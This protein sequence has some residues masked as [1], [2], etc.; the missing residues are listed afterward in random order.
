[1]FGRRQVHNAIIKATYSESPH[2]AIPGPSG[3]GKALA[4]DTRVPTP[5]GWTTMGELSVGDEVFTADGSP[6]RVIAATEIMHGHPCYEI[7][8]S[9]GSVIVADGGHMWLVEDAAARAAFSAAKDPSVACRSRIVTTEVMATTFRTRNSRKE[10]NYAVQIAGPLQCPD[11]DLPIAP[12]TLGC[13]LGDGTAANSSFTCADEEILDRI[14]RDGYAVTRQ[15]PR[16]KYQISN[17]P[18]R[19]RRVR[20]GRALVKD[21]GC[22][23]AA[24]HVGVGAHAMTGAGPGWAAGPRDL[25]SAAP[26]T[27]A[28]GRYKSLHEILRDLDLIRNKHIPGV[29]LRASES[30]RRDLLAGLLD[31]DGYCATGGGVAYYSTVER[32]ARDVLHLVS[33]LGYKATLRS[34]TATLYGK[35]CGLVWIVTFTPGDTVFHLPRKVARQS[36]KVRPTAKRRYV[37]DIRPVPSSVPVRCI[38]VDSPCHLYLVGE[39]CIPTHKSS[40]WTAFLLIQ[41]MIAGR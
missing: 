17:L 32:L 3:N 35:D 7:E 25:R 38:E 27:P 37:T 30:Q 34:K 23:R 40:T 22:V 41:E 9:D 21:I 18:E 15:G 12:F 2:I 28:L 20:L 10:A 4:L 1:M 36:A 19:D 5:D 8:F 13:W 11:A 14:R 6:A 31:T 29:Y 33:T 26:E 16:Y 39:T 24:A